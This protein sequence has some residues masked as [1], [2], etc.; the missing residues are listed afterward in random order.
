GG[1]TPPPEPEPEPPAGGDP[2]PVVGRNTPV[3]AVIDTAG[4]K[5]EAVAVDGTRYTLTVPRH[6]L[7]E[8]VTITL[9]P[10]EALENV[11]L[12]G[13]VLAASFEPDGLTFLRPAELRVVSP[14]VRAGGA[15]GLTHS[16]SDLHVLPA[17]ASG[18]TARL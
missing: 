7:A 15:V 13:D 12:S 8:P 3:S 14:R 4:G 9:T 18:D 11:P 16:G 17:L 1:I 5:I 10:L 2:R 6:A